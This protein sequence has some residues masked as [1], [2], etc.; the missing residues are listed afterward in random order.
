MKQKVSKRS[1]PFTAVLMMIGFIPLII[2]SAVIAFTTINTVT[3][4]LE[5]SVFA[6]LNVA[7]DGLRQ[8]Y[9]Y[10][11]ENAPSDAVIEEVLSYEHDYVDMLKDEGIEM[12]L[13]IGDTRFITSALNAEGKRNEGTQMD[14]GIWEK[15]KSGQNVTADGVIIGGKEYYVYYMPLYNAEKK[16]IGSTWAGQSEEIVKSNIKSVTTKLLAII[17]VSVIIFALVIFFVSKK[18]INSLQM[19][20]DNI[21][22]LAKGD[23]TNESKAMSPIK[24]INI[25]SDDAYSLSNK[26]KEVVS[27]IKSASGNVNTKSHELSGTSSQISDTSDGVSVA[28]QEMAK[29][30]T[31][32]A[33]VVS[34]TTENINILSTAIQT[35]SDNAEQLAATAAEM[36]DASRQSAEALSRLSDNMNKMNIAVNEISAAM[37]RTNDAVNNVNEKVDGIT[38][39]AAQTNLLALNASIEAARAGESGKGFAVVAEEIG[40]LAGESAQTAEQ[41]KED[42]QL[43]LSSSNEA[44]KRTDDITAIESDVDG[45]LSNTVTVVDKLIQNVSAT[46]DGVNNISALTQECNASKEQIVDAMSSLSAISEENA[47]STEQTGASMEELNATVNELAMAAES[48]DTVAKNLDEEL[49]FFSV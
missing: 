45:V 46:V 24:E 7:A 5:N 22:I 31:E 12:T 29:G 34:N 4:Q 3:S 8:Y 1:L 20:I 48:L 10:N 15:V 11:I 17:G 21:G 33:D 2:V 26:L 6:K 35:V 30:A 36:D 44:S 41:I 47:A 39:I 25:I 9:Q 40:K 16:V 32:Q 37:Q 38:S 28:V 43:L 18:V 23:L 49:K 27:S 42:M 13:F 14:S 19:V